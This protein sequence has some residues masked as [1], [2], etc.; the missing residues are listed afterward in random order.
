MRKCHCYSGRNKTAVEEAVII[1]KASPS[2]LSRETT[3]HAMNL[4]KNDRESNSLTSYGVQPTILPPT[5]NGNDTS[6]ESTSGSG[7]ETSANLGVPGQKQPNPH[8]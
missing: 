1:E 4:T 2:H 5:V 3:T 6:R 8:S 7:N